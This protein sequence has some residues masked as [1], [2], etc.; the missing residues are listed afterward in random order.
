M[1]CLH[2]ILVTLLLTG[3]FCRVLAQQST[4]TVYFHFVPVG[5]YQ[6]P[7]GP[8]RFIEDNQG[9]LIITI[10]GKKG[11]I[12]LIKDQTVEPLATGYI[13]DAERGVDGSIWYITQKQIRSVDFSKQSID[14]NLNS[15]FFK[16]NSQIRFTHSGN[17]LLYRDRLGGVWL[18]NAPFHVGAGMK[19]LENPGLEGMV[20][21]FPLPQTTD[22][23]GNIWGLMPVDDEGTDAACVLTTKKPDHWTII[24]K[25]RGFPEDQWNTIISNSEG[26]IWISGKAGLCYFDPRRT[27]HGW[28]QFPVKEQFKGETVSVLTLTSTGGVLIA[29][30]NGEILEVDVTA[31]DSA[32]VKAVETEG[33]PKSPVNAIY[34]DR[35]G[36]IWVVAG[37][38]LYRQDK[39]PSD[40]QALTSMPYGNH[41][42]SGVE[43]N[44][45][46]Y[47]AGGGAYNGFP[48]VSTNFDRLMIYDIQND[49]WELSPPMSMNR[50][51][52][53]ISVL[54]GK[55]WV[56]G[57]FNKTSEAPRKMWNDTPTNSVEIY[58]P[59]MGSW[60]T[61]PP[62]DVPRAETVACTM[63]GR[64]YVFGSTGKETFNT[65]SIAPGEKEWRIE[66]GAP[67]PIS[68]TDGCAINDKAYII[69]GGS[70]GL[71][72]YDP[73]TQTWHTDLPPIPGSK[74]T[75][76]AAL[77]AYKGKIWVISGRG[78]GDGTQVIIYSPADKSWTFGPSYPV[79]AFWTF[80][81]EANGNL[82]VP[83]GSISSENR[84]V[85]VYWDLFRVLKE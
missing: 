8:G 10:T 52:C 21:K 61:G 43:L 7:D 16:D 30:S 63:K 42:L 68:Q 47:T 71:I 49:R 46:I 19:S 17:E 25:S 13:A 56:I 64:L 37:N 34:T 11:L 82:Y 3:V 58:D 55:I 24:D 69:A 18:A 33:L 73:D 85:F 12:G 23:F 57:G 4:A 32:I 22:P 60:S 29:L 59:I 80:G 72:M 44:G 51:Y 15:L 70:T 14:Q 6:L 50:R 9:H 81:I 28:N 20:S 54:D 65:I 40:W 78:V 39:R 74:P 45:K 75:R 5:R 53:E 66:P 76:S 26:I 35:A 84:G 38:R 77:A 31:Y 62:M 2:K 67:F 36:R 79:A 48:V 1:I 41:D 83:G 27:D